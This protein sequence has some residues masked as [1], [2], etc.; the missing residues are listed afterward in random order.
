MSKHKHNVLPLALLD[1]LCDA[2]QWHRP[3]CA[4][5]MPRIVRETL[6]CLSAA[7]VRAPNDWQPEFT[8]A[9]TMRWYDGP[10]DHYGASSTSVRLTIQAVEGVAKY[11]ITGALA[12][13][14]YGNDQGVNIPGVP[15]DKAAVLMSVLVPMVDANG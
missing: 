15:L 3:C 12:K 7:G 5:G 13:K 8:G 4:V 11:S 9:F 14:S 6:E 10:G 2:L 1:D